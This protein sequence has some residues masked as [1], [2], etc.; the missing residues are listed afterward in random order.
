MSQGNICARLAAK[1]G[2]S[3]NPCPPILSTLNG[4][5]V[6]EGLASHSGHSIR[7]DLVVPEHGIRGHVALRPLSRIASMTESLGHLASRRRSRTALQDKSSGHPSRNS[8]THRSAAA[9]PD[10]RDSRVDAHRGRDVDA[11]Q[12]AE[13]TRDLQSLS[14][15][16]VPCSPSCNCRL[17]ISRMGARMTEFMEAHSSAIRECAK[18]SLRQP[19]I[20]GLAPYIPPTIIRSAQS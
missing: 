20:S 8:G 10:P 13:Q 5:E 6:M 18:M 7:A 17:M 19:W 16:P 1:R 15:A 14:I 2:L 3:P 12:P 11:L 4:W 9:G